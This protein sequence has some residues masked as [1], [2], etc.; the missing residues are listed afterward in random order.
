MGTFLSI[1]IKSNNQSQITKLLQELSD[2][3]DMTN[4]LYPKDFYENIIPNENAAPTYLVV[5]NAENGW[6]HVDIN[7][8]KKL[9]KWLEQISKELN[10]SV[11][12]ILGQTVSDAYYFLMY[13]NGVLRREIDI[14]HGDFEITTDIGEKFSFEKKS[15]IPENE[16]DYDNLF[17]IDSIAEY[18]SALGF[19]L[20]H[21]RSQESFFVLR[22]ETSHKT[23]KQITSLS[24]KPWWKFW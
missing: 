4:G 18:C 15:L 10:T 9:H 2:A 14:Y 19:D 3:D 1:H 16:E 5:S 17:D 22:K 7:S 11:I 8:F 13:E 23:L 12:Q 6:I 24:N 20:F 21:D